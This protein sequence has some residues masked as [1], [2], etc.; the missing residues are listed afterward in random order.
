MTDIRDL[1]NKNYK[2]LS[3]NISTLNKAITIDAGL[4]IKIRYQF[5]LLKRGINTING[6]SVIILFVSF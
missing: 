5:Y 6:N 1:L 2:T 4:G 3:R